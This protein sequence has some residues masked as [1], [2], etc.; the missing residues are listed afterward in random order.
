MA[1]QELISLLGILG[2]AFA[3]LQHWN[4]SRFRSNIKFDLELL[5]ALH[6]SPLQLSANDRAAL[7]HCIKLNIKHAYHT[8]W[9]DWIII[10]ELLIGLVFL[11]CALLSLLHPLASTLDQ[12]WR[13]SI[14]IVSAV[15]SASFFVNVVERRDYQRRFKSNRRDGSTHEHSNS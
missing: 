6:N 15:V 12:H 7:E 5:T 4:T 10:G 1:L 9:K 8:S 3:W 11:I 13:V 2:G 14:A